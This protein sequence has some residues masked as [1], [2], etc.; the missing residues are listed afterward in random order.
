MAVNDHCTSCSDCVDACP[1]TILKSDSNGK[2]MIVF[3]GKECTFCQ[4][5]AEA[6]NS[7]V[8]DLSR[9]PAWSL[10]ADIKPGC[11]QEHGISCQVCRDTCPTSAIKVDLEKRPF[12]QLRIESDACTGCGGCLSV[13]PQDVLVLNDLSEQR[14]VA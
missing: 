2:P 13:C 11:L 8:F 10:K 12:G 5:C 7:N 9:S 4:K 1:E 14:E 6:C 3:D